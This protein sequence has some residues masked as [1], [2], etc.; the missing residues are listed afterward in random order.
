MK[1]E[2]ARRS[3]GRAGPGDFSGEG[4]DAVRASYRTSSIFRT[5]RNLSDGSASPVASIR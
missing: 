5:S 4:T 3:P 2:T 1:S